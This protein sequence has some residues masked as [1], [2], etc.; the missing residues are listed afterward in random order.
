MKREDLKD[1][2]I[3]LLTAAA[4]TFIGFFALFTKKLL[5]P[6]AKGFRPMKHS[7]LKIP[8]SM[9]QK[10]LDRKGVKIKFEFVDDHGHIKLNFIG[11]TAANKECIQKKMDKVDC[12][13]REL[14]NI[15]FGVFSKDE[16]KQPLHDI[17]TRKPLKD[18][19][20]KPVE[21][22]IEPGYVSYELSDYNPCEI[23]TTSLLAYKINPC[24]P[25]C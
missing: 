18:W 9:L 7:Y 15:D 11:F 6:R 3:L 12:K 5:A 2:E 21:C 23:Q 10:Y 24:P 22:T 1:R 14:V 25:G 19:Y 8:A 4:V 17:L 13:D 20:L 16:E